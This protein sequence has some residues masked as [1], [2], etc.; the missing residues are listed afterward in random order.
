LLRG[1]VLRLQ[2]AFDYYVVREQPITVKAQVLMTVPTE[3]QAKQMLGE[4]GSVTIPIKMVQDTEFLF[5]LQVG[6][7][8]IALIPQYLEQMLEVTLNAEEYDIFR[9]SM[10]DYGMRGK[11]T[12]TL[13]LALLP[14]AVDIKAPLQIQKIDL[15][16][17]LADIIAFEIMSKDGS[18]MAWYMDIPGFEKYNHNQDIY[19]LF[20]N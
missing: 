16:A 5:P 14:K 17:L 13:K 11:V 8:W 20:K 2:N 10:K 15:W 18:Q 19:H 12:T 9:R 3:T 7:M 1:E 6:D 4:T